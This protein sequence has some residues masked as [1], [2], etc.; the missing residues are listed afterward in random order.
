VETFAKAILSFFRLYRPVSNHEF[1]E[2]VD[3]GMADQGDAMAALHLDDAV[4]DDFGS[5]P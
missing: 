5:A 3:F 1:E 2:G 4:G